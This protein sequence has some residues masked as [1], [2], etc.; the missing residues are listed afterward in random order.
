LNIAVSAWM[1]GGGGTS[2]Y[3]MNPW[4]FHGYLRKSRKIDPLIEQSDEYL[5]ITAHHEQGTSTQQ[6]TAGEQ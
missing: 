4:S 1:R 3:H 2:G 5:I 6:A